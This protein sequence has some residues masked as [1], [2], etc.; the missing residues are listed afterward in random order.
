MKSQSIAAANF[1]YRNA[2]VEYL[3]AIKLKNV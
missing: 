1:G 3:L 2:W